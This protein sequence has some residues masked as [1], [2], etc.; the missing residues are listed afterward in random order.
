[1]VGVYER[2]NLT[3]I[4]EAG[5]DIDLQCASPAPLEEKLTEVENSFDNEGEVPTTV[6]KN[7]FQSN[8][9][10]SI[11]RI[12]SSEDTE[13]ETTELETE[14]EEATENPD[15]TGKKFQILQTIMYVHTDE[16]I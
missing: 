9:Y 6:E 10:L 3:E 16:V 13:A 14:L 11:S 1:L 7:A 15:D 4:G 12:D 2:E 5:T 8:S